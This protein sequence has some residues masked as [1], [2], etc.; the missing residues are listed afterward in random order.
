M[1]YM[2]CFFQQVFPAFKVEYGLYN[3]LIISVCG[4]MSTLV[5]GVIA[6][7]FETKERRMTKAL[8]CIFGAVL[9]APVTAAC[10]L[11]TSNFHLSLF[12]M[13]LKFLVS[14]G[15]MAPS[16]TMIQSTVPSDQQGNIVS[17]VLFFLTI[18]GCL[19]T[20]LLGFVGNALG[21]AANPAIYG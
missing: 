15:W 7:R 17:A 21:A 20:V 16:F 3:A 8:V 4:F 18:A 9:A 12:F 13:G 1:F 6:D 14:E 5:S 19:S 11:N 2:P 10:V